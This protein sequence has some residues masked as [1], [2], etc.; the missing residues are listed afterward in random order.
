MVYL[1]LTNEHVAV[2]PNIAP[3]VRYNLPISKLRGVPERARLALKVQRITTCEQ[4]LAAAGTFEDRQKLAGATGLEGEFLDDLVRRADMARVSGIGVVFCGMLDD[5]GVGHVAQL[6]I[7]DHVDLHGR[8][9]E[10]N[11]EYR[12]ARRSPTPEEVEDWIR[13]ARQLP[14]LLTWVPEPAL[15][16]GQ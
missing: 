3:D 9:R 4:L 2:R 5:L 6:A 8:L 13:Q 11:R 12:L 14:K 15:A 7:C 1:K 16:V 10:Y